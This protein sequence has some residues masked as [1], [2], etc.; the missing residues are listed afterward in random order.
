MKIDSLIQ[1]IDACINRLNTIKQVLKDENK[2]LE[3]NNLLFTAFNYIVN[4]MYNH[5]M[6]LSNQ[7]I[8]I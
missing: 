7:F 6:H 8:K 5:I 4:T 1:S 3:E 2:L